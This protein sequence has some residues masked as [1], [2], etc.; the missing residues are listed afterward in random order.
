M[1]GSEIVSLI[2]NLD[3]N[4]IDS[5]SQGIARGVGKLLGEKGIPLLTQAGKQIVDQAGKKKEDILIQIFRKYVTSYIDRH[6]RMKILGMPEGV[7]LDS[8]YTKVK[9]RDLNKGLIDEEE[10]YRNREYLHGDR[11]LAMDVAN[12]KQYMI[13]LGHPGSGKTT[14]LRKVGIEAL[15]YGHQS[16]YKHRCIPVFLELRNPKLIASEEINLIEAIAQEFGNCG[17]PRYQE[18]T[19]EFLEKGNLLIIL[20]G[21]DE[22]KSDY[23]PPMTREIR[24]LLDKYPKNRFLAS[25]RIKAYGN[26]QDFQRFSDVYIADFDRE[27]KKTFIDL[28]F[29]SHNRQHWGE[30]CWQKLTSSNNEGINELTKTPLLL[31]LMCILYNDTGEFPQKRSSLYKETLS[32]L[33]SKWDASKQIDRNEVSCYQGLDSERKKLM[34]ADIAFENFVDDNLYFEEELVKKQI[35]KSLASIL[36]EEN[37]INGEKVLEEIETKHGLLIKRD[38]TQYSFSHLTLQEYLT[39]I[40]IFDRD[41]DLK[42]IV[43]QYFFDKRWREVFLLLAGL[44]TADTLL[45]EMEKK[46]H[47]LINSSKL[48]DLLLWVEKYTDKTSGEIEAISK[49]AI[50]LAKTKAIANAIAHNY[51]I[52][53]ANAYAISNGYDIANAIASA[54]AIAHNYNIAKTNANAII[55]AIVNANANVKAIANAIAYVKVK[56]KAID[57]AIDYAIAVAK[58][59]AITKTNTITKANVIVEIINSFVKYVQW[60]NKYQISQNVDLVNTIK[61]LEE[62]KDKIPSDDRSKQVHPNFAQNLIDLWLNSF[63]L[64]PEM[65]DLSEQELEA[66]ENYFYGTLLMINCKKAANRYSPE[67]WAEIE[68]K[69]FLYQDTCQDTFQNQ[70]NNLFSFIG[71]LWRRKQNKEN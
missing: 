67:K 39:A 63:H 14:F 46:I 19:E 1:A 17:L 34:L 25:C 24:N 20:D 70:E 52:A 37:Y 66:L 35:V 22:V 4:L 51:D 68:S 45:L 5:L 10:L 26:F 7:G 31:A 15:K 38:K 6:G 65:I 41:L 57:Y 47:G 13:V 12:E 62:L 21:L 18:C 11:Y 54:N 42:D 30:E 32:V 55:N 28:W 61:Q 2:T 23:L 27:Q 44:K 48:R 29:A 49:R 59:S 56:V 16:E 40:Y 3:P 36:P 33:L 64:T 50:S 58:I 71:N 43:E 60:L 8:I 69:M 53:I 9:F